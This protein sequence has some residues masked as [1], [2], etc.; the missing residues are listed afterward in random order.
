M[1]NK[2]E[3]NVFVYGTLKRGRHN[4]RLLEQ[5]TG[6]GLNAVTLNNFDM[7]QSGFPIIRHN[8]EGNCIRGEVY[9]VDENTLSRLDGLEG[10]PDFYCREEQSVIIDNVVQVAW[11]YVGVDPESYFENWVTT[12]LNGN[13]EWEF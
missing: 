7:C 1:S 11:I 12:P 6:E 4:H 10:H 9:K 2:K 8:Q 5:Y 13:G 3:Y